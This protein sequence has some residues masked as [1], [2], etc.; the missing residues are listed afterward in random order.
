MDEKLGK[1]SEMVDVAAGR[2]SRREI[3]KAGVAAGGALWA[4][5]AIT[6]VGRTF[7]FADTCD[8]GG[9]VGT[10]WAFSQDIK[11]PAVFPPAPASPCPGSVAFDINLNQPGP[12]SEVRPMVASSGQY[13]ACHTFNA[14]TGECRYEASIEDV[15]IRLWRGLFRD[16]V[17]RQSSLSDLVIEADL[18]SSFTQVGCDCA[19]SRGSETKNVRIKDPTTGLYVSFEDA[20]PN[21]VAMGDFIIYRGFRVYG[22]VQ[23]CEVPGGAFLT[24]ALLV[25][26][27][28]EV[29]SRGYGRD[30]Y[31]G[32]SRANR[33]G[34][35]LCT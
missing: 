28:E 1:P 23:G 35:A 14:T 7:A 32:Y 9:C 26:L 30:I 2:R 18:L 12:P 27:P 24:S 31:V 16:I 11:D 19:I 8:E 15:R 29:V 17:T 10:S 20:S 3:L 34:C 21:Y 13:T 33:S 22:N 6:P 25:R 4:A 5:W